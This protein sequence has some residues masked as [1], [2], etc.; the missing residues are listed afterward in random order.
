[1]AT[2]LATFDYVTLTTEPRKPFARL[3][4]KISTLRADTWV[5]PYDNVL[6]VVDPCVPVIVLSRFLFRGL[7]D[8]QLLRGRC[9]LVE[10]G[11]A[12]CFGER[13][14]LT[15]SRGAFAES[16]RAL[17]GIGVWRAEGFTG[18]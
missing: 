17:C 4:T 14:R 1:V 8:I 13:C 12:W 6:V 16:A 5:R 15:L 9:Y 3:I 10:S 2:R 11:V 7:V 18:F